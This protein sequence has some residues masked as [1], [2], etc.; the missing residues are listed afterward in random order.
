MTKFRFT[1][2]AVF[3]LVCAVVVGCDT[4]RR[5]TVTADHYALAEQWLPDNALALVKNLNVSPAWIGES[6]RFWY[7]RDT[8]DGHEF[9]VVDA[10]TSKKAVAFD[11]EAIAR[12]LAEAGMDDVQS[13]ALPFSAFEFDESESTISFALGESQYVCTVDQGKCS[14]ESAP[15][16]EPG[17][18]ISPDGKLG[19]R[20]RA[21]NLYVIDRE[22]RE[23]TALTSDGEPHFGYGIY[24]GNWYSSHVARQRAGGDEE[25]PPMETRWAPDSRHILATRLDERHV[26]PYPLMVTV[27]PDGSFRPVVYSPRIPLVGEQP[28]ELEWLVLDTETGKKVRL[29]LPY[30]ELLHLHQDMHAIRKIWWSEGVDHLYVAAYGDTLKSTH[31][32]EIDLETGAVRRV[33]DEPMHPRSDFSSSSYD[34]PN[35][36]LNEQADEVIWWSQRDG[37]GHLYLYDLRS[38]KLKHRITEGAWL[39]RD[40]IRVDNEARRIYFTANGKEGGNPYFRYLYSVSFEGTELKLLTPEPADH[41]I[42]SPNIDPRF[43]G[44]FGMGAPA[45]FSPDGRFVVYGYSTVRQPT[46]YAIRRTA[47]GELVSHF[48]QTDA[49][50]LYATGWQDPEPFVAKADDGVTD[51]YGVLYKPHDLDETGSYPIIDAQ[52]ASPLTAVV[53][54]NYAGIFT[55]PPA[56]TKAGYMSALGFASVIV[57][58]RGTTYRDVAFAHHSWKNL[59]QIG[60][61]DHIAAIKELANRYAW[62]DIDR[63]GIHGGSYGGWVTFRAMFEFGDFFK[64]GVTSVPPAIMHGLYPDYHWEAFHGEAL[65]EDESEL[66]PTSASTPINWQ[67]AN[68]VEEAA[69]L[70]GKLLILLGE[71]DENV[72]PAS[73]LIVVDQLIKLD[74]DFDMYYYPNTSHAIVNTHSIHRSMDY[75]VEHLMGVEPPE[76]RFKTDGL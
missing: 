22:T 61:Y 13:T 19:V 24:Y 57:D 60:L 8:A 72:F 9:V 17:V 69:D 65:Y 51:L 75:F 56:L 67:N 20:S 4:P 12:G 59:H 62:M 54:H 34:P 47:D 76:Y 50:E 74:K 55:A 18:L 23:E 71:I 25:F 3:V 52:Y 5:N 48:E 39:V 15:A 42:E 35:V 63:V 46:K 64:V 66:K 53:P 41:A 27:P 43:L 7:R 37:W 10:E 68:A 38:G 44:V 6:N 40:V 30:D 26:E 2:Q 36:F 29:D 1:C 58:A 45:N 73:T 31:F 28:A 70:K 33:I 32:L 11:H 14:R 49:S 21:G 16:K